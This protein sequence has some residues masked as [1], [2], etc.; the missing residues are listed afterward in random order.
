MSK[1]PPFKS[2]KARQTAVS[3]IMVALLVLLM[4]VAWAI[5]K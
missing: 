5:S 4:G 3:A 1:T 2:E